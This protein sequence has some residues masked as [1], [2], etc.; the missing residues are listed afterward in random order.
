[1]KPNRYL[2]SF[3]LFTGIFFSACQKSG[4][5]V[6]HI[7]KDALAV[8]GL[9][10]NNL[11][12][13]V[14]WSLLA[15]SRVLSALAQQ[16]SS[17][18]I[19]QTGIDPTATLI[20][21]GLPDNRLKNGF[22]FLA[23]LP[24]QKETQFKAYLKKRFPAA[25]FEKSGELEFA[26]ID[27]N[28]VIGWKNKL[29]IGAFHS[30]SGSLTRA[31]DTPNQ[32]GADGTE[33]ILKAAIRQSF[34]LP[35]KASIGSNQ[36]FMDLLNAAHDMSYWF[37]YEAFAA[38]MPAENLNTAE[39]ILSS[40]KKL[41][42]DTYLAG[43]I[44]FEKG[45]I[46]SDARYYFNP[47]G[48]AV[49]EAFARH[50]SGQE[51]LQRVPGKNLNL[52]ANLHIAPKG[53]EILIDSMGM[54]PLTKLGLT[55]NGFS[56]DSIFNLFE[57][58]FL[59]TISDLDF[60]NIHFSFGEGHMQTDPFFQAAFTFEVK[61]SNTLQRLLDTAVQRGL[62]SKTDQG[63]YRFK[64]NYLGHSGN[65]VVISPFAQTVVKLLGNTG[66]RKWLVPATLRNKPFV[67]YFDVQQ[68]INGF[69]KLFQ[70]GSPMRAADSLIENV[71][72]YGDKMKS[73]Y[74]PFHG[75]ISFQNKSEN[76][77]VQLIRFSKMWNSE[78]GH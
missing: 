63:L 38:G 75:E 50:D 7:P 41:I 8:F 28:T 39:V 20:A 31:I 3:F 66:T 52:M 12:K 45:K 18:D 30:P 14:S 24:L 72:V 67:F 64:H 2:F 16:D 6:R 77:L 71:T 36:R 9:N 59:F 61:S 62:I 78:S 25:R 34:E 55:E 22:K 10:L 65:Y 58:D 76:S 15:D 57:G 21:Y 26:R 1:M 35:E 53:I 48:K 40:Q 54:L 68:T 33:N 73:E 51:L 27:A 69:S 5:E 46:T 56:P 49:I 43:S 42:R 74:I 19:A 70:V 13:K 32:R 60:Q 29:A 23:L 4:N 17:F 11:N 37:N 47:T 44:D